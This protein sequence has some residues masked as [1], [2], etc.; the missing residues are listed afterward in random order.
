MKIGLI[1]GI[2]KG[3]GLTLTKSLI[4][5][6]N[7]RV[8]GINRSENSEIIKLKGNPNFKF[9]KCDVSNFAKINQ[10]IDKIFIVYGP[11]DFVVNNAGVRARVNLSNADIKNYKNVFNVNTLGPIN[12][13][14]NI[15]NK[16]Y[17]NKR[18]YK[19]LRVINISSIVGLRGFKDLS[20]YACS[21]AALDAFTKSISLEYAK[22]G[23][24]INSI[25][26]GFFKTSYFKNFKKNKSLYNWTLENIPMNRWGEESE[27]VE[28]LLFLIE[29]KSNYINGSVITMDGGWTAK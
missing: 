27:L 25:A 19:E 17:V 16:I 20:V 2:G 13:T 8:I 1:T 11:I 12:I 7:I 26:P 9:Y 5:S 28:L 18:I 29:S 3:I 14:K 22:Y 6:K 15:I 4:K 21:K 23:L 24:V 10:I